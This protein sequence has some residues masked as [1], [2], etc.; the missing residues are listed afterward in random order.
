MAADATAT[1]GKRDD[2]IV[3]AELP[4]NAE[5]PVAALAGSDITPI[6]AFYAR[7]H[8]PIPG[9]APTNW[10]LTVSGCVD[11]PL[12]L[13]YDRL[14]N[15]FPCHSVVGDVGMCGLSARRVAARAS[16]PG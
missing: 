2:M 7:N 1:W 13:T 4:Y 11:K 15:D 8:G 12:T 3:H 5:P 16:D 14:I 9:I 10:S 6:D